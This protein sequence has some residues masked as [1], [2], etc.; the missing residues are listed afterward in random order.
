MPTCSTTEVRGGRAKL[1]STAGTAG[2]GQECG[3]SANS[4]W[5]ENQDQVSSDRSYV[6]HCPY[7]HIAPT[8]KSSLF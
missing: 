1:Q 6:S 3:E 7:L 2:T 5:S 8:V 4:E